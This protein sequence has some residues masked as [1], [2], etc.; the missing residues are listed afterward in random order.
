MSKENISEQLT[1]KNREIFK[2]KPAL[3]KEE[4]REGNVGGFF[5]RAIEIQKKQGIAPYP[6]PDGRDYWAEGTQ[7]EELAPGFH[8]I[9]NLGRNLGKRPSS[10]K[11]CELCL[12]QRAREDTGIL[13]DDQWE[14]K[15]NSYPIFFQ[16]GIVIH[17]DHIRQALDKEDIE[18]ILSWLARFPDINPIRGSKAKRE[19]QAP[20]TSNGVKFFYNGLHAGATEPGHK[21]IHYFGGTA[22]YKKLETLNGKMPVEILFDNGNKNLIYRTDK[23]EIFKLKKFPSPKKQIISLVV[24]ANLEYQKEMAE[25]LLKLLKL[26]ETNEMDYNLLGTTAEGKTIRVFL[27]PRTK[28]R[29]VSQDEYNNLSDGAKNWAFP[30]AKEKKILL[31]ERIKG[32]VLATI[33][34]S[35]LFVAVDEEQYKKITYGDFVYLLNKLGLP[36]KSDKAHNLLNELAK[37]A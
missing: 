19:K 27:T 15:A 26:I 1:N 33:E 2:N 12:N 34:F 7:S 5:I 9:Y 20:K 13:I 17:R 29:A 30:I 10:D 23:V 36:D 14:A 16:H 4:A 31:T 37:G 22:P 8:K 21:H 3:F 11:V 6:L 32:R 25:E 28:E 35:G 18:K 24:Q